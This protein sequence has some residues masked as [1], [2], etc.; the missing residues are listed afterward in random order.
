MNPQF[1]TL[2][3]KSGTWLCIA[4][5]IAA[6]SLVCLSSTLTLATYTSSIGRTCGGGAVEIWA[7]NLMASVCLFTLARKWGRDAVTREWN[8]LA[9]RA[10]SVA[11]SFW[12]VALGLPFAG[13]LI[14][15]SL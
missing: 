4:G 11:F 2:N 15:K 7:F 6:S 10:Y 5:S 12:A 8:P 14:S 1:V 13:A 3:L 9:R